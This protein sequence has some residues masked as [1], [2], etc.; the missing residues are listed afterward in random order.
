MQSVYPKID[1]GPFSY[2]Y[3]L[4]LDLFFG[5]LYDFL[6]TGRMYP[7]IGNQ[8]VQGKSG[9]LPTYR[10]ET[11]KND[12]FRGI[13]YNDLH[14][15]SGFQCPDVPSFTS[16]DPSLHI[17]RLQIKYGNTIFHRFLGTD[18]LYGV[19]HNFLG[20]LLCRKLGLLY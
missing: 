10:I 12:R 9:N 2:L 15:R 5:L 16:D 1:Y 6:D 17:V 7:T 3:D 14:S 4:F 11:G 18:T 19:D 13:I 20:L 8:F